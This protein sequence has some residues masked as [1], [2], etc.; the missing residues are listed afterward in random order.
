MYLTNKIQSKLQNKVINKVIQDNEILHT[1]IR[2]SATKINHG[3]I[4]H[5]ISKSNAKVSTHYRVIGLYSEDICYDIL[6]TNKS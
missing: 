2:L 4:E 5:K 6:G 1:L 3:E